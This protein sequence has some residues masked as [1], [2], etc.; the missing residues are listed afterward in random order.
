MGGTK[1]GPARNFCD[2]FRKKDHFKGVLVAMAFEQHCRGRLVFVCA[3]DC[4]ETSQGGIK[5]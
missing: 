3:F 4:D 5:F 1:I 2:P